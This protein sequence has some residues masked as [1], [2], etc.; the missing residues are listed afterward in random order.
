MN[1]KDYFSF[2]RG[3]KRGVV[4]FL[5]IIFALLLI[6]PLTNYIKNNRTTDFSDFDNKINLFEEERNT[7]KNTEKEI[8]KIDLFEF[9]PNTITD[10]EWNKLG[11]KDWQIKTIN[12]YK[13]KGGGWKTKSDVSKIYG[14]SENHYKQLEPYILLPEK[15]NKKEYLKTPKTKI[16]YFDFNPNTISKSEWKKLGFKAWQIKTIFNYKSKGGSWKSK[17]DVA[18]IYGLDNSDYQ[19]LAPYILLPDKADKKEYTS[20]KKDYTKKINVNSANAKELTNLKGINSEKYAA[21]IIKYRNSLGGFIHKEQLKEVWNLKEE[22]YLGFIQ[23]VE[24]GTASP[25]KININKTTLEQLKTHPYIDWK[26]ANA[27]IKYKK[28][29]GAYKKIEDIKKIHLISNE[30]YL[31]IAPYLTTK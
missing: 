19:K 31:K 11:F 17:A 9:N 22:T 14:L 8:L 2:T 20:N 10:E 25:N 26:T 15:S 27:I 16:T 18:K 1:L 4:F 5:S 6:V 30:T 3:E 24:L 13:N 12:N 7:P 29:N 28:A 23:Q 21:I